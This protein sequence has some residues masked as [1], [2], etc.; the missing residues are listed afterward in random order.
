M[1]NLNFVSMVKLKQSKKMLFRGK[2]LRG[3][4]NISKENEK[5]LFQ[6]LFLNIALKTN[7][8]YNVVN[9]ISFIK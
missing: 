3:K 5:K 8:H 1:M 4:P 6:Q 9:T 2:I 7:I